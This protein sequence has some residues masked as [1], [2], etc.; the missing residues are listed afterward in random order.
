M[1]WKEKKKA[2][3]LGKKYWIASYQNMHDVIP[4]KSELSE[5]YFSI[6]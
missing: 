3:P 2:I 6:Q 5:Y 1:P 4:I